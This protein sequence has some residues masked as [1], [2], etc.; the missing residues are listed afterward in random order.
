MTPGA[1]RGEAPP[2]SDTSPEAERVLIDLYRR[3]PPWKKLRQVSE[4]TRMVQEL[5]LCD[6]RRRYPNADG[7]RPRALSATRPSRPTGRENRRR[8]VG[9]ARYRAVGAGASPRRS[10]HRRGR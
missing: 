3:A 10:R 6:I 7:T 1:G 2:L 5:A 9:L 8:R 4:L